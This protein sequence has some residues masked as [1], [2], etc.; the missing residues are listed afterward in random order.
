[1]TETPN[2]RY[3]LPEAGTKDWN[4]PL[5]K[6]FKKID[7]D[8]EIRD[9]QENRHEYEPKEGSKYEATDT[10]AI[11]YADGEKWILADRKLNKIQS[12][13]ASFGTLFDR[14]GVVAPSVPEAYDE[15][16]S[17]IDEGYRDI[18]LIEDI[19]ESGIT[20]PAG[21]KGMRIRGYGEEAA[22][23]ITD[24]ENG[25]PV[26]QV[27]VDSVPED[28]AAINVRLQEFRISGGSDSEPAIYAPDPGDHTASGWV[29]DSVLVEAGPIVLEGPRQTLNDCLGRNVSEIPITRAGKEMY[30]G[31]VLSGIPVTVNGGGY[32][33]QNGEDCTYIRAGA[34]FIGGGV[35]F[36]NQSDVANR[37]GLTL[38]SCGQGFIS[39]FSI[40]RADTDIRLGLKTA[41][42]GGGLKSSVI[43]AKSAGGG[44][45][46]IVYE[47]NRP[48]YDVMV[49]GSNEN[50]VINKNNRAEMMFMMSRERSLTVNGDNLRQI[51]RLAWGNNG[52][53]TIDEVQGGNDAQF[54]V[55]VL[56]SPP[57]YPVAGSEVIA[58]GENW[59]PDGDGNAEKVAYDGD[60]WLEVFDF[61]KEFTGNDISPWK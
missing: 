13:S 20:I 35:T 22:P 30:P 52:L 6:N 38:H 24:P 47:V 44:Q 25:D 41:S 15:I 60:S 39:N 14:I 26:I 54:R 12:D 29:L 42:R 10:G 46:E 8:V 49:L 56:S 27:D 53:I 9:I 50:I 61:G 36:N 58:D 1:M 37:V 28:G 23:T 31:L 18:W 16:Q 33:T 45:S 48:T 32:M 11:Y 17:A 40:E 51:S 3:N 21:T 34:F 19:E 43:A 7:A 59:D 57:D 4:I 55:P 2:H 5:N